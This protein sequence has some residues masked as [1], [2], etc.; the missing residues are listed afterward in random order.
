[1]LQPPELFQALRLPRPVSKETAPSLADLLGTLIRQRRLVAAVVAGCLALALLYLATAERLYS[2]AATLLIDV[3]QEDPLQKRQ[4]LDAQSEITRIE[5]QV[6]LLTSDTVALAVVR[7]HKLVADPEFTRDETPTPIWL[8]RRAMGLFSGEKR[9]PTP[10]EVERAVTERLVGKINPFR[11]GRTSVVSVGFTSIDA[12]KAARL[13]NALAQAFTEDQLKARLVAADRSADW[14]RQRSAELRQQALEADRAVEDFKAKNNIVVTTRGLVN[15]QQLGDLNTQLVLARAH[16]AEQKA[17][18]D[19]VSAIRSTDLPDPVVVESL[20]NP[21]IVRLR[22]QYLEAAKREADYT[23]RY[24]ATHQV[25]ANLQSEMAEL[26][27]SIADEIGRIAATYESDYR[28]AKAREED[29]ER[30]VAQLVEQAGKT[31]QERIELRSLEAAAATYRSLYETFIQQYASTLQQQSFPISYA[32]VITPAKPP[33]RPSHPRTT[34][35]LLASLVGGFGL[36]W[37]AAY[38]REH[39]D[40][41]VRSED[42]IEASTGLRSIGVLPEIEAGRAG[43]RHGARRSSG[44]GIPLV[45]DASPLLQIARLYPVSRFAHTIRNVRAA[46]ELASELRPITVIGIVSAE[47]G[48]GKS[49]LAANLAQHCAKAEGRTL[50]LDWHFQHPS[51]SEATHARRQGGLLDVVAGR[52]AIEEALVTDRESGLA[53]LPLSPGRTAESLAEC[54]ASRPFRELMEELRRRYDRIIVDLPS[55]RSSTDARAVAIHVDASV[56]VCAAKRTGLDQVSRALDCWESAGL[57]PVVGFVLNRVR[58][59][60]RQ[61]PG[62]LGAGAEAATGPALLLPSP[63]KA[64]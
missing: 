62:T 20:Q 52:A 58:V 28:I 27:R 5:S 31:N 56:L 57:A 40:R 35:V 38:G 12:E 21:V 8:L 49:T 14:L 51:L 39:L 9:P 1:M 10:E 22:Q 36:G 61:R 60:R 24:G 30:S 50:L 43:G 54:L 17:R 13:A 6:Q 63:R 19:R 37:L 55:L 7:Q 42:Q 2:A 53:F 23:Q 3:N 59:E 44:S 32:R 29:L 18:F 46:V 11:V 64:A 45:G 41:R 25:V 47:P 33:T 4:P 34:L 15:E 16:S 26:R 48:A